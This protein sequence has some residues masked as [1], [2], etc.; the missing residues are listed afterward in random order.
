VHAAGVRALG[1]LAASQRS[2]GAWIPLWFG[3]EHA[4]GEDNAV[5][6]TAR[7][8]RGLESTLV[9]DHPTAVACRR[10]AIAW[11]LAAQHRDGGWGGDR[12]VHSSV[13][14]TGVV[15][16]ALG[17]LLP[18]GDEPI[19]AAIE[20]GARWLM[21]AVEQAQLFPSPL[22]L[23]FAR[24]WYYEELYPLIFALEGVARAGGRR[25]R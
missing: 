7:V 15:L 24:L 9:R 22:G 5:Y 10:R 12:G 1:Y 6:G 11:L 14:E 18:H 21:N 16:S 13:E 20:R 4:P 25:P 2:D 17:G 19:G 23:Y 8:L 3:N